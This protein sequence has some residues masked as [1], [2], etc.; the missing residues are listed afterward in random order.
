MRG[1]I[2]IHHTKPPL[3]FPFSPFIPSVTIHHTKPPL[4][5]P[6]SPFPSIIINDAKPPYIFTLFHLSSPFI[7]SITIHHTSG[8]LSF[9]PFPR[10][11]PSL[12]IHHTKLPLF[13]PFFA[14][15]LPPRKKKRKVSGHC[16]EKQIRICYMQIS[17]ISLNK[18]YDDRK[19]GYF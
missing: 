4:F 2:T 8:N 6:F 19:H 14:P 16:F 11:I 5:F 9:S 7:T 15:L 1:T 13:F 10:V 12:T 18:K 3:L 17:V